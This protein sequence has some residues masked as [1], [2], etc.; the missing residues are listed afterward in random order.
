LRGTEKDDMFFGDMIPKGGQVLGEKKLGKNSLM[1][2]K[3][4]ILKQ[5]TL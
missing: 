2:W 5:E 1:H 3:E 4:L